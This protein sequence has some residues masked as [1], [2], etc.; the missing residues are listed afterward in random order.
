MI[1]LLGDWKDFNIA[2]AGATAALGGLVIVAASVNIAAIIKSR[3]LTARLGS[4]IVLLVL[5]LVVSG[6]GLMPGLTEAWYGIALSLVTLLAAALQ[7]AVAYAVLS[8]PDSRVRA[9]VSKASIGF[10][11]IAAYAAASALALVGAPSA[12]MFTAIGA[13]L[14][15]VASLVFSWVALVEVLR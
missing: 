13:L 5:A 2:M 9:R 11:P 14:A 10:F 12:L 1:E 6:I 7:T 15:I 4:G 3:S 8:D